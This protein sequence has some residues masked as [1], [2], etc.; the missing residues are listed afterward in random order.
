MTERDNTPPRIQQFHNIIMD[1]I[2]QEAEDMTSGELERATK[3][4]VNTS[5][6]KQPFNASDIRDRYATTNQENEKKQE[7]V[8]TRKEIDIEKLYSAIRKFDKQEKDTNKGDYYFWIV[9]HSALSALTSGAWL[10]FLA[11]YMLIDLA[12]FIR[13]NEIKITKKLEVK[14]T[15]D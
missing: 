12:K 6:K 8:E 9:V 10:Y 1:K 14:E 2:I 13:K 7:K 15:N 5:L 3:E 4:V 11:I